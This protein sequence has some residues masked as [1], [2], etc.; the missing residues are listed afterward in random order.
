MSLADERKME[1]VNL[2]LH[3]EILVEQH[4]ENDLNKRDFMGCNA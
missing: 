2:T 4:T 3:S 1:N